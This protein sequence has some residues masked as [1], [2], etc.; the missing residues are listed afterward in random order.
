MPTFPAYCAP[1]QLV[2]IFLGNTAYLKKKTV[3][4]KHLRKWRVHGVSSN[5]T[6]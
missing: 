2:A 3:I 6:I 5:V 1:P 4:D